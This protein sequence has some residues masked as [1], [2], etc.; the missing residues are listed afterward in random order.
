MDF[1]NAE[2]NLT[3]QTSANSSIASFGI[4]SLQ[5][6]AHDYLRPCHWLNVF[7]SAYPHSDLSEAWSFKDSGGL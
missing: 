1:F 4:T 5:G 6:Y 2:M 3:L 7:R